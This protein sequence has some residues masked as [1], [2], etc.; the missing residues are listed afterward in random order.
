[1][2]YS[3][4]RHNLPTRYHPFITVEDKKETI[5]S[6]ENI[7]DLIITEWEQLVAVVE[8]ITVTTF[9]E[10]NSDNEWVEKYYTLE[11]DYDLSDHSVDIWNKLE[12]ESH[13]Q[14]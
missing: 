5:I 9:E 1:M 8:N 4:S 12:W 13:S 10:K 11:D 6:Y 3:R 2:L 7:E 14:Q